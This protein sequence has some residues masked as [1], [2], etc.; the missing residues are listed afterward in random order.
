VVE[1][2]F[3]SSVRPGNGE[4]THLA[5]QI[6]QEKISLEMFYEKVTE[7]LLASAGTENGTQGDN[8]SAAGRLVGRD[9][10][11]YRI[12]ETHATMEGSSQRSCHVCA[13]KSKRQTGKTAKKCPTMYCDVGLGVGQCFEVYHSKLNYWE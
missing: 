1:K 9:H 13:E 5:Q 6:K 2:T 12:P 4:F 10:F 8:K 3:L 11:L 7:G